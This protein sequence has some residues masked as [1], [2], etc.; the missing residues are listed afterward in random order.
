MVKI[1]NGIA[2]GHSG[3]RESARRL[4]AALWEEI[5]VDGGEQ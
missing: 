3:D 1:C 4:F 2:L 5:S